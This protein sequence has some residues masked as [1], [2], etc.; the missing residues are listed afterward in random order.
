[1]GLCFKLSASLFKEALI[2]LW[3]NIGLALKKFQV[4][5]LLSTNIST[6]D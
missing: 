1:M 5:G 2:G 3:S 4:L 6:I